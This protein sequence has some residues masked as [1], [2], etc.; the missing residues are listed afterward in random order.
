MI[1]STFLGVSSS[2]GYEKVY[3]I[4]G[5]A[6]ILLSSL[7]FI[8]VVIDQSRS[9]RLHHPLSEEEYLQRKSRVI[10]YK[11]LFSLVMG[12]ISVIFPF[13]ISTSNLGI[14][15]SV[16]GIFLGVWAWM[17]ILKIGVGKKGMLISGLLLS[18]LGIVFR[19]YLY[20]RVL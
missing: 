4:G 16:L 1:N 6:L 12:I 8:R 2:A 3:L 17:D 15:L 19:L 7:E 10:T 5:C 18:V 20:M 14:L 13:L 11:S 9:Y